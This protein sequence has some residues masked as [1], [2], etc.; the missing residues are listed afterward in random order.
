MCLQQNA[1]SEGE[2]EEEE[3]CKRKTNERSINHQYPSHRKSYFRSSSRN[4]SS[5]KRKDLAKVIQS[6]KKLEDRKFRAT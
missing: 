6:S 1:V 3:E 4:I 5:V 2:V